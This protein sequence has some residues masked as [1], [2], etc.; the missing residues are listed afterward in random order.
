MKIDL[1]ERP[2]Y[3]P[4]V[5]RERLLVCTERAY[6]AYDIEGGSTLEVLLNA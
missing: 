2:H 3:L 1:S 5:Q 4:D 6:P